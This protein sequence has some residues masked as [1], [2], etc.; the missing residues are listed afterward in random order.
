MERI[1]LNEIS[2]SATTECL[3]NSSRQSQYDGYESTV[4]TYFD[5]AVDSDNNGVID[6]SDWENELESNSYAI[7]KLIPTA[8]I[9]WQT[10]FWACTPIVITL[11]TGMNP[12]SDK[13]KI[14]FSIFDSTLKIGKLN[15]TNFVEINRNTSYALNE[16]GYNSST[17]KIN[18]YL[19]SDKTTFVNTTLKNIDSA[20]KNLG[21]ILVSFIGSYDNTT[22]YKT[23]KV[24][25][26]IV[27][28]NNSFYFQLQ[29]HRELR[30]ALASRGVYNR[31][32][33]PDFALEYIN[34]AEK[35][36]LLFEDNL[37]MAIRPVQLLLN[38]LPNGLNAMVYRDWIT[39][40]YILTFGG[41]D[42]G[43]NSQA[44][45]VDMINNIA[46]GAG[47]ASSQFEQAIQ[48][49]WN[50]KTEKKTQFIIAGHS[51]GGGLASTAALIANVP[52]CT[53]NPS[54]VNSATFGAFFQS[55]PELSLSF[56]TL[57]DRLIERYVVNREILNWY[58]NPL[59]QYL[60]S[61][62]GFNYQVKEFG[63]LHLIYGA[64][65]LQNAVGD[66]SIINGAV[67]WLG[68]RFTGI[69]GFGR[70]SDLTP[71][72]SLHLMDQV[73]LGL[74]KQY[75]NYANNYL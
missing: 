7:G 34:T 9:L 4:M 15:G 20:G 22:I 50:I 33:L 70:W 35:L 8:G 62:T 5:V 12:A 42:F 75:T 36:Q 71:S 13:F 47:A 58:V 45:V 61:Q 67:E 68:N 43:S 28:D 53:F 1:A 74:L 64:P 23:D 21:Q 72:I 59:T 63:K 54:M 44:F 41:T 38:K 52:A 73:L 39:G 26:Q 6:F 66:Y 19:Q 2:L 32:D 55:H 49:A 3:K 65:A 56:T 40:E 51:L 18:L 29:Q 14:N 37:N 69:Q 31:Q 46:Q 11:P 24:Q 16:L 25:Y 60:L 27:E 17:G 48:I 30:A 57:N 10:A